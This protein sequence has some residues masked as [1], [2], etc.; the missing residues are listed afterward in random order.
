MMPNSA[1]YTVGL[2]GGIATGKSTVARFLRDA[3][4]WVIDAD[5]VSR[6]LTSPGGAALP[7]IREAFGD[8][9]FQG[10]E[11]NRAALGDVVFAD[12]TARQQLNG[13]MFP[14]I[15]AG[16]RAALEKL[17]V[18]GVTRAVIDAPIL[19]EMGLDQ[20]TKEIWVCDVPPALQVERLQARNRLTKEQALQ[21][22]ASQMP[23]GEW[24]KRADHVI[25]TTLPPAQVRE[26]VL[27]LWR[28]VPTAGAQ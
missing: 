27:R 18:Q 4:A 28:N 5:V 8:A 14:R 26:N 6:S 16:V 12:E 20:T 25:D 1:V 24:R 15:V 2:T 19:F 7:A 17:A 21:R 13:I 10:A 3:G 22:I 11:L 23:A 9:V